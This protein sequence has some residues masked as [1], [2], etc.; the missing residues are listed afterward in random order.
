M[1][2]NL[3]IVVSNTVQW[4][5]SDSSESSLC[6][7]AKTVVEVNYEAMALMQSYVNAL[8]N[9]SA[10]HHTRHLL[11]NNSGDMLTL[12]YHPPSSTSVVNNLESSHDLVMSQWNL[13][14]RTMSSYLSTFCS[15][16]S[17]KKHLSGSEIREHQKVRECLHEIEILCLKVLES[18]SEQRTQIVSNRSDNTDE[19]I[20]SLL[21]KHLEATRLLA[22]GLKELQQQASEE[23]TAR[24]DLIDDRMQEQQKFFNM[25]LAQKKAESD[26]KNREF[27]V[28]MAERGIKDQIERNEKEISLQ[29]RK[30]DLEKKRQLVQQ[31]QVLAQQ[32]LQLEREAAELEAAQFEKENKNNQPANGVGTVDESCIIS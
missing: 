21:H 27:E 14:H 29:K 25:Q 4:N 5:Y 8:V 2:T 13:A 17:S 28:T 6:K 31:Q 19:Q 16:V 11:S 22:A 12:D 23:Q 10:V 30:E 26:L 7:L 1:N 15:I 20:L 18:I 9:L 24:L 3:S 32:E